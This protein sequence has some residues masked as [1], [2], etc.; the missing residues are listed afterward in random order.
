MGR[1][2]V[3]R[4]PVL[5][6]RVRCCGLESSDRW[7]RAQRGEVVDCRFP[8]DDAPPVLQVHV[9]AV[10]FAKDRPASTQ[11]GSP[12]FGPCRVGESESGDKQVERQPRFATRLVPST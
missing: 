10:V 3:M 9:G 8:C 1:V 7:H 12:D 5:C 2:Q 4:V 6:E 11:N